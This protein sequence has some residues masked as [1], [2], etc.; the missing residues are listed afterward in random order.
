MLTFSPHFSINKNTK[1]TIGIVHKVHLVLIEKNSSGIHPQEFHTQKRKMI[2]WFGPAERNGG[3]PT[4]K[5]TGLSNWSWKGISTERSASSPRLQRS[6][7]PPLLPVPPFSRGREYLEGSEVLSVRGGERDETK[8]ESKTL[9][10][11]LGVVWVSW[12]EARFVISCMWQK[13]WLYASMW[14]ISKHWKS[15]FIKVERRGEAQL[16]SR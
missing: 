3:I 1:L 15:C 8:A 13:C 10:S 7:S 16:I 12:R 5:G 14:F 11:P 2:N 9:Y 4:W 6:P